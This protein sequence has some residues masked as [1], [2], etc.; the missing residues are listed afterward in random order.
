MVTLGARNGPE[1][2][3][4]SATER[5]V[6]KLHSHDFPGKFTAAN[7]PLHVP[8]AIVCNAIHGTFDRLMYANNVHRTFHH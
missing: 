7:A 6:D 3:F 4:T 5:R 2:P 8:R 1:A